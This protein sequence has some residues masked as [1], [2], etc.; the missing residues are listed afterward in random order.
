MIFS[1]LFC[2]DADAAC[3]PEQMPTA[4]LPIRL[5]WRTEQNLIS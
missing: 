2:F 3:A 1:H 5:K 4:I